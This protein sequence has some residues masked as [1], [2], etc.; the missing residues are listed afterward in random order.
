VFLAFELVRGA[1]VMTPKALNP[2]WALSAPQVEDPAGTVLMS[3]TV[4]CS[5]ADRDEVAAAVLKVSK[6]TAPTRKGCGRYLAG[7]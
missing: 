2:E 1:A 3:L 5:P 4:V 6:G 7:Q